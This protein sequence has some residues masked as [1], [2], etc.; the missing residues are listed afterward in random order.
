[1]AG[2]GF[3]HGEMMSIGAAKRGRVWSNLR[4]RFDTFATWARAVGAKIATESIDSET[5]LAGTLKPER[6]LAPS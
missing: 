6:Y 4:L 1:L 2:V 5:V 3:E